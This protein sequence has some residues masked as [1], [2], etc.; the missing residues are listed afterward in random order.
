MRYVLGGLALVLLALAAR[1]ADAQQLVVR[2]AQQIVRTVE[3]PTATESKEV[4]GQ[5]LYQEEYRILDLTNSIRYA[6]HLPV[7]TLDPT[8]LEQAREHNWRMATGV[9]GFQHSGNG[10]ENII[11]GYGDAKACMKGWMNSPGHRANILNPNY[12]YIGVSIYDAGRG[13]YA[14]QRFR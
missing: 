7:L 10:A 2:T 12:R 3:P 9:I 14:T 6:A 4:Q 5:T 1:L 8:L 13:I 11:M